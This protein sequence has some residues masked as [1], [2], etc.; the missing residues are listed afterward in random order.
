MKNVML[1]MCAIMMLVLAGVVQAETP[2]T[3]PDDAKL[4]KA[5]AVAK[6]AAE[7]AL[8]RTAKPA[9]TL[10]DHPKVVDADDGWTFTWQ[11]QADAEVYIVTVRVT[12]GGEAKV[13]QAKVNT[14]RD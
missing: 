9:I 3:K 13:L 14:G 6:A 10:N 2:A 11:G 5:T 1:S 7:A 8:N 12:E 4:I